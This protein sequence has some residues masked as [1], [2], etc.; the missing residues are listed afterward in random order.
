MN[1]LS[2]KSRTFVTIL[3]K[4]IT[5]LKEFKKLESLLN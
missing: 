5:Q 2:T 4:K 3:K 1:L